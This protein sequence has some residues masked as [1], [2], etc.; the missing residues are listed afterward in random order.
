MCIAPGLAPEAARLIR[1]EQPRV[2]LDA[3]APE[4][5]TDGRELEPEAIWSGARV[6]EALEQ[7]R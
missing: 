6:Y 7:G 1:G 3:Y 2:P 4:R 5:F